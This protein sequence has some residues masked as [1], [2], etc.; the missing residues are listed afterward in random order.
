MTYLQV[1]AK[2]LERNQEKMFGILSEFTGAFDFSNHQRLQQLLLEYRAGMESMVVQNGHRLAM[3]LA[4]RRFMPQTGIQEI[5]SGVSQLRHLKEITSGLDETALSTISEELTDMGTHLFVRENVHSACIG[6]PSAL[7]AGI[8]FNGALT[9]VLGCV[10]V[11]VDTVAGFGAPEL[12]AGESGLPREGWY[13]SSSVSFVAKCFQTV[14]RDH[15]DSPALAVIAKMLR[16][17][18]LHREIREKG[19]AYGGFSLYNSEDGLFFFASYRDPH[20]VQTLNAFRGA[21]SF[22]TSGDFTEQDI[23]EALLQV[24]SEIDRPDPPGPSARKAFGRRLISLTDDARREYKKALLSLTRERVEAVAERYFSPDKC[25]QA[26]AVISG[27]EQLEAA[28]AQLGTDGLV[29]RA[30]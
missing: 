14:R 21:A 19:G 25:D 26:V 8:V 2:C 5:W 22:I 3:S 16:S 20:I 28:N 15:P 13:T 27:K 24:C 9:D 23:N 6:S 18:Y 1:G 12:P 30:I 7:D 11:P 17:L 10:Q 4:A 29:L